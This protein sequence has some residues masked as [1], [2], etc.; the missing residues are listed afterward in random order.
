MRILRDPAH[1]ASVE[2]EALR[3]I[4]RQRFIEISMDYPYDP[5]ETGYM[6][7]AEPGDSI[8]ALEKET[9]CPILSGLF[10]D[11][12][13]PDPAFSPS[14]E[15]IE[16]FPGCFEAVFILNDGGFGIDLFIPK[17]PGIDPE[18]LAMCA[19]FATP[20]PA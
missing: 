7:I 3:E 13:F 2:D 20:A 6:V 1:V 16:E 15:W 12:R 17:L 8:D 4:I 5:D 19:K 9:G 11:A 10:D 14:A 18:L